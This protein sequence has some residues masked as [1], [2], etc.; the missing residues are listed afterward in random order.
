MVLSEVPEMG[1]LCRQEVSRL[2]GVAPIN[3]D[4]GQSRGKRTIGGGRKEVR[5]A[6]W[7]PTWVAIRS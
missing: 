1:R 7:M 3:R 5:R 2:A 6:L 4:S